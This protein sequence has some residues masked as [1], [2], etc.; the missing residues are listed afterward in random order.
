MCLGDV[1]QLIPPAEA[2]GFQIEQRDE[3][4]DTAAAKVRGSTKDRTR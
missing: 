2:G 3:N 1:H 4:V